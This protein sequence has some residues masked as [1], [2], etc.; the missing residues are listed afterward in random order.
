MSV[1]PGFAHT[2]YGLSAIAHIAET[3][4]IQQHDLYP[5][6]A[7]RLRAGFELH[8]QYQLGTPMPSWLCGGQLQ[9]ELGPVTEVAYNALH[10]RMH[11]DLPYTEKL[12]SSS[13]QQGW[14]CSPCG[15]PSPTPTIRTEQ[16]PCSRESDPQQGVSG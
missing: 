10:N 13:A 1:V 12:T 2:G 3:S 4:R 16:G 7:D 6:V 5:Q 8:S 14:T 9:R 15:K 11:L